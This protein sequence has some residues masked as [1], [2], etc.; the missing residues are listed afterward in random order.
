MRKYK[1]TILYKRHLITEK[2]YEE[3][4]WK[5]VMMILMVDNE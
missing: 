4:K 2:G 3:C 1:K 5:T